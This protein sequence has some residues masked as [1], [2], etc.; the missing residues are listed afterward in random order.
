MNIEKQ[1]QLL[2]Y[3]AWKQTAA[4]NGWD[5]GL[6]KLED[7]HLEHPQQESFGDYSTNLAMVVFGKLKVG[8]KQ[9]KTVRT[10]KAHPLP[11]GAKDGPY[12]KPI[13]P[14][15]PLELAQKVVNVIPKTLLTSVSAVLPGFINLTLDQGYLLNELETAL[16]QADQ[17][18][19]SDLLK[20]QKIMVE[21]TDPN[22]FKEFHIGHLYS[23]IVGES[24]AR[25]LESQGGL[26]KR[27]CYQGDVGMHVA[28]SI[29][30]L[31]KEFRIKNLELR[32]VKDKLNEL[33]QKPLPERIKFLGQAYALGATAF[34]KD[35]KSAEEIKKINYL[36]YISGQQYLKEK[37]GWQPKV[38][39]QQKV[40][41]Q[42]EEL[43]IVKQLYFLGREWSLAYFETIYQRLGTKFDYYFFESQ[44]GEYGYQLVMDYL[45]K[46]VFHHSQG[47]IVYHPDNKNLHTRV[48][49]NSLGLPTYESKDLGLPLRKYE[50]FKYDRSLIIT[51]NEI[52]VYFQVVLEALSKI[53]PELRQKN[54]HLSHGMVRLPSGKMSSRTGKVITG[55]EL[56]EEV[57]GRVVTIMQKQKDQFTKAAME[58]I[59]ETVAIAAIKYALLKSGLGRDVVFDFDQSISLEGNSGPYLQYTYAR[60]YSVLGKAKGSI[61]MA[62]GI[63]PCRVQPNPEELSILRWLYRY[64]EAVEQASREYAPN[65]IATYLYELAQ[66][67]NVFYTKHR[68]LEDK[69][70]PADSQFR[71]ALTA[72]TGQ[73]L[74]NGLHLLGI[75][76]LEKM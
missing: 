54:L 24:L 33:A 13:L 66:R 22:P 39:Y 37:S 50:Q 25:L 45:A 74:Q 55:E 12:I 59:C 16:K 4:Q 75:K 72:A 46:G 40:Q 19:T 57:K 76:T 49:V 62:I 20:N 32:I 14:V 9:S 31:I 68:I 10:N 23:N 53:N 73:V 44:V 52:D 61:P 29:W 18:G 34:E 63:E 36:V 28:K 56:I 41:Y 48:F 2:L 3:R 67:F 26:V 38:N 43:E 47:A 6:L 7:I 11:S 64:P 35:K 30:G 65:V 8:G 5:K 15:S 42:G 58:Q 1:F 51:G 69:S 17:Y 21:F 60:I 70:Q 71:L 27:A